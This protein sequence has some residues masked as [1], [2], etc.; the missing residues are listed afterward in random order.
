MQTMHI[1]ALRSRV[2]GTFCSL[3][4]VTT[5]GA[6]AVWA[7]PIARRIPAWVRRFSEEVVG[8]GRSAAFLGLGDDHQ[9]AGK[10]AV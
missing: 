4:S 5:A 7:V 1:S 10:P 9:A 8:E 2:F 6:L 3:R